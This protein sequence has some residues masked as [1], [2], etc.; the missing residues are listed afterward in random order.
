MIVHGEAHGVGAHVE[1]PT[2]GDVKSSGELAPFGDALDRVVDVFH[3]TSAK[4]C[5][6]VFAQEFQLSVAVEHELSVTGVLED[7]IVPGLLFIQG[8]VDADASA[9]LS[10]EG[11]AKYRDDGERLAQ[12]SFDQVGVFG[13]CQ[14]VHA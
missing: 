10:T 13:G 9:F 5:G 2:S 6:A 12:F 1:Y 4:L 8:D 7:S 3:L 14:R 11:I